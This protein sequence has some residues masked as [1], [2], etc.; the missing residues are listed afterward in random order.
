VLSTDKSPGLDRLRCVPKASP[1]VRRKWRVYASLAPNLPRGSSRAALQD[2]RACFENPRS[3]PL[4]GGGWCGSAGG[5]GRGW[6]VFTRI[7]DFCTQRRRAA[8]P[9]R[10]DRWRTPFSCSGAGL[11]IQ[12]YICVL[13]HDMHI[14]RTKKGEA[15]VSSRSVSRPSASSRRQSAW[16]QLCPDRVPGRPLRHPRPVTV[17]KEGRP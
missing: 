12:A 8:P 9:K 11:K 4:P 16:G 10:V 15:F 13:I 2:M 7:R 5:R 17:L 3:A 1:D 6:S 14:F